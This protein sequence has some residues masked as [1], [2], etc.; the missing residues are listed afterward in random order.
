MTQKSLGKLRLRST[1]SHNIRKVDHLQLHLRRV[2]DLDGGIQIV[3]NPRDS[4]AGL[5]VIILQKQITDLQQLESIRLLL[6]LPQ[7][8]ILAAEVL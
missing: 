7:Q 6:K 3:Q 4:G 5:D 1:G 2:F 8:D